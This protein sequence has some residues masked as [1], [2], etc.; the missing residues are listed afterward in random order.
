MRSISTCIISLVIFV[1]IL[2]G[3]DL[4]F[5]SFTSNLD[6]VKIYIDGE[7]IGL[8]DKKSFLKG[9]T[10]SGLHKITAK[11]H[12]YEDIVEVV[13]FESYDVT[14]FRFSFYKKLH[15]TLT[16]FTDHRGKTSQIAQQTKLV[17]PTCGLEIESY[18][19]GLNVIFN[20]K[21]IGVSPISGSNIV[22]GDNTIQ[23][24]NHLF[25]CHLESDQTYRFI[26]D[27]DSN[28]YIEEKM[29]VFDGMTKQFWLGI[30]APSVCLAIGVEVQDDHPLF[31]Y[32][33]GI[34]V[35]MGPLVPYGEDGEYDRLTRKKEKWVRLPQGSV[36]KIE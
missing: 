4:S 2:T 14:E 10:T 20:G 16:I 33:S 17:L 8:I 1:N 15:K 28:A 5:Y 25:K 6:D 24:D 23:I 11:A 12:Q 19:P 31:A 29:Y 22:A 30:V 9:E 36:L 27:K 13:D 32:L 35:I 21:K 3:A 34:F 26:Y 7:Y 18:N